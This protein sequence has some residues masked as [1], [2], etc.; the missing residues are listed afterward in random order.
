MDQVGQVAGRAVITI[1]TLA[2]LIFYAFL[3]VVLWRWGAA[4]LR[5]LKI[6]SNHLEKMS[7]RDSA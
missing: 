2:P 5:E 3:L 1:V 4:V 7:Q 6:I